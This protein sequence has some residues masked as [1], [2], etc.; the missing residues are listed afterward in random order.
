MRMLM[1]NSQ[2]QHPITALNCLHLDYFALT[3]KLFFMP[4]EWKEMLLLQFIKTTKCHHALHIISHRIALPLNV[5]EALKFNHG[6]EHLGRWLWWC[7][8]CY[9]FNSHGRTESEFSAQ[10]HC[11][12]M[13]EQVLC[14][15]IKNVIWG[16]GNQQAMGGDE[17]HGS[18]SFNVGSIVLLWLST[19]RWL[20]LACVCLFYMHAICQI[21]TS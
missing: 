21:V 1:H 11:V 4:W 7:W 13:E 19:C 6:L 15:G 8:W 10:G 5:I 14:G 17:G 9:I 2:R 20:S 3:K 12:F 18:C 16:E